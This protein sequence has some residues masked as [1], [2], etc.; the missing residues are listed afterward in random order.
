[1]LIKHIWNRNGPYHFGSV[2]H[3]YCLITFNLAIKR[4]CVKACPH[5][6]L[7]FFYQTL[8]AL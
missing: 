7:E 3:I 2:P 1:M 5:T 8:F 4:S 6:A